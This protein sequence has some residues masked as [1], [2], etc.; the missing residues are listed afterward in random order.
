MASPRRAGLPSHLGDCALSELISSGP[1]GHV[2]TADRAGSKVIVKALD[3][4][5]PADV[6][7]RFEREASLLARLSS[8]RVPRL[9]HV[10]REHGHAFLVMSHVHGPTLRERLVAGLPPLRETLGLFAGLL[11]ALRDVHAAAVIHRDVKP[12]NVVLS[13]SG[14][15]LV[16]FGIA[17]LHEEASIAGDDASL[18]TRDALLGTLAYSAP[19]QA[20]LPPAR[21]SL[22]I[23]ACGVVLFE[24]LTGRRPFEAPTAAA[25]LMLKRRRDAPAV[26][27]LSPMALPRSLPPLVAALLART[28][29]ARPGSADAVLTALDT[30]SG[31]VATS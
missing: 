15:V 21:P 25:T 30:V 16:D 29:H 2:V 1:F 24:C 4:S 11:Y 13:P 3:A 31:A 9:I 10:G 26:E 23:Y 28:P 22:D 20:D 19:E 7:T 27:S 12:E 14:P 6:V 5:A 8:E 17:K 18:T